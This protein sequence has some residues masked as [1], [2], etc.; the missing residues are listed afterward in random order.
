MKVFISHDMNDRAAYDNVA[1]ALSEAGIE[2][3]S[4]HASEF[5]PKLDDRIRS[6]IAGCD[7]CVFVA[8]TRSSASYWCMAETGAFWG[9]GMPVLIFA[10]DSE[11]STDLLPPHLEGYYIERRLKMLVEA[12]AKS[13]ANLRIT[14]ST[15]GNLRKGTIRSVLDVL[16]AKLE[17][18]RAD[19]V[20]VDVSLGSVRK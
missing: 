18:A 7:I 5:S 3:W 10:A 12:L 2:F 13:N 14:K 8:T 17:K 20:R 19:L 6:A 9:K 4:P 11:F 1:D 15:D 16:R